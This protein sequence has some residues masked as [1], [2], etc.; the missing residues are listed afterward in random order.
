MLSHQLS[1]SS[2]HNLFCTTLIPVVTT[3]IHLVRHAEADNPDNI[4]YGRLEGFSLSERGRRQVEALVRHFAHSDVQAV[5]S[6]PLTRALQTATPIAENLDLALKVDEDLIETETKLEGSPGDVRLLRNPLNI[7]FFLN[8]MRP[9]WGEPYKSI[10]LRMGGAIDRM[11]ESHA[12][13]EAIAVSHQTPVVVARLMVEQSRKPPW[14]AKVP[15]AQASVTTLEYDDDRY[16][17]THY[18]PVGSEIT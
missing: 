12:G 10:R 1:A 13:A 3:L 6:S 7:R 14:R 17:T 18:D 11:R 16:V 9:S 15:C 8:P 5:Y 2:L 4:W